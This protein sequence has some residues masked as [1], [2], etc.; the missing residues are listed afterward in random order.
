MVTGERQPEER[1]GVGLLL[2][3]DRLLDVSGQT[4]PDPG[5]LVPHVLGGDIDIP[6]EG[7]LERDVG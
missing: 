5:D 6:I 1:L 3:D 7:E 4:V 2:G